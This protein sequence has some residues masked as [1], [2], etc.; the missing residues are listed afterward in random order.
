MRARK[1]VFQIPVL[2][3][4]GEIKMKSSIV[5]LV[6]LFATLDSS[7]AFAKA[8]PNLVITR[9]GQ[10]CTLIGVSPSSSCTIAVS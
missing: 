1:S 5:I 8:C 9:D 10:E 7:A 6:L 2:A 4:E 3:A